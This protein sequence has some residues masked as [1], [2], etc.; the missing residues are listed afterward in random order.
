M[1]IIRDYGVW[2]G[3]KVDTNN[4]AQQILAVLNP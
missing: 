1:N 3:E 4:H 2:G